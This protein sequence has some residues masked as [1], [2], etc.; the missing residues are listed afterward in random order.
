MPHSV[1]VFSLLKKPT[2]IYL[3]TYCKLSAHMDILIFK[4]LLLSKNH[5]YFSDF[6]SV[7]AS[8]LTGKILSFD[9]YLKVVYF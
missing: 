9:F 7:I 8:H 3:T 6:E 5:F 2:L 4:V 1:S